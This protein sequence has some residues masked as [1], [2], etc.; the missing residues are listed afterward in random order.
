MLNYL[1]AVPIDSKYEVLI[2]SNQGTSSRRCH[3]ILC[4]TA[5][6]NREGNNQKSNL[7]LPLIPIRSPESPILLTRFTF[8]PS[9]VEVC[10]A[11][12]SSEHPW[13]RSS[14]VPPQPA[15]VVQ[16]SCAIALALRMGLSAT[17]NPGLLRGICHHWMLSAKTIEPS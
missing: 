17:E 8:P 10:L 4:T 14:S 1:L 15:H 16:A 2:P 11:V 13:V 6:T 12:P 9:S 3:P 5:S 7:I